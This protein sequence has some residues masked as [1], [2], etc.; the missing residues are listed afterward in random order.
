M[1]PTV[2]LKV[3]HSGFCVAAHALGSKCLKGKVQKGERLLPR[4]EAG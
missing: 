2:G 4:R 1:M 3:Q